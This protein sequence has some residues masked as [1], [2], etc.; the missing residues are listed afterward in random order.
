MI[1][2]FGRSGEIR[3]PDPLLPKQVRA[4]ERRQQVIQ[5]QIK[6]GLRAVARTA[7]LGAKGLTPGKIR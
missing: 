5:L 4:L 7:K 2:I 3:T 6:D 1:E